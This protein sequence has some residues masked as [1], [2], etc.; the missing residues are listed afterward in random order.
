MPRLLR[1]LRHVEKRQEI[2]LRQPHD[3][4][5]AQPQHD[6]DREPRRGR[7][8]NVLAVLRDHGGARKGDEQERE[9][10]FGQETQSGDDAESDGGAQAAF[11]DDPQEK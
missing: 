7:A 8:Q 4:R 2:V 5:R 10:V 6:D 1:R 3:V 11:A 9:V